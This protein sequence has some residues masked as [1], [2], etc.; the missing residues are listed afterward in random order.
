MHTNVR[1]KYRIT[2]SH[3]KTPWRKLVVNICYEEFESYASLHSKNY[4]DPNE[5]QYF[6]L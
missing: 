2:S 5:V 3:H 6:N 1:Y 4:S